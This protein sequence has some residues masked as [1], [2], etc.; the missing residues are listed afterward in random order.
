M[1]EIILSIGMIVKNEIR[2]L[3]KCL[4]ALEPLRKAVSCELVIADTGSTD[5]TREIAARY[6][7][8]FFDQ[9]WENDFSAARNAVL[10]RCTGQWFFM[11]DAD[12]YLDENIDELVAFLRN[13]ANKKFDFCL[14][15]NSSF[16]DRTLDKSTV[17]SFLA[18]RLARRRPGLR[19]VGKIHER[20]NFIDGD[21]D[22]FYSLSSVVLWHDGYAYETQEQVRRKMQRNMELLEE[23]LRLKPKEPLRIVQCIEASRDAEERMRYIQ[24]G[25]TEILADAPGWNQQGAV[26]LSYAVQLAIM[27]GSEKLR[28]WAELAYTRYPDSPMTQIDLNAAMAVHYS[29]CYQ[30]QEALKAA[31][32][33]WEGVQKLERNE[34]PLGVFATIS[35]HFNSQASREDMA[36]LQAEACH[37]LNRPG[38]AVRV[39]QTV[40]LRTISLP[41]IKR[42]VN[43]LA[44]LS[45]KTN[46]AKLFSGDAK[47]ILKEEPASREDWGRR[48]ALRKALNNMFEQPKEKRL[49]AS[50]L[51]EL[52][53]GVYA[54]AA[55][56]METENVETMQEIAQSIADWKQIPAAVVQKLV[57]TRVAMPELFFQT[58]EYDHICGLAR[59]L[60][61]H[62][63]NEAERILQIVEELDT[64]DVVMTVWRFKLLSELCVW[65]K[66]KNMKQAEELFQ[67]Y[68]KATDSYLKTVYPTELLQ[69]NYM[70]AVLPQDCRF[71]YGCLQAEKQLQANDEANC[72]HT[73]KDLLKMAPSMREMV[74][75]LTERVAHITQERRMRMAV[76]PQL[77]A[78]AKQVRAI[79]MQYPENSPT[80]FMLKSSE[81]YQ[82]MKFLI[83]D[84]NLDD[85]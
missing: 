70:Y 66:W 33:Y 5:G 80:A 57:E 54:P 2:C 85:M 45:D 12:E 68:C 78:M 71:A 38:L 62:L 63:D 67:A 7:D 84:P 74:R 83:E 18:V 42:L 30:W 73:L 3:E 58:M 46:V 10:D 40:P 17:T 15:V 60:V 4:K 53:D 16:T 64:S 41:N 19:F 29:K 1:S 76:T 75:F 20:F 50:V 48:D 72:I 55:A 37:H 26:L 21:G 39:L 36:L 81:Q 79:L 9:P 8:I 34:F 22:R 6:A 49:P 65:F 28:E 82:K 59:Y 24:M 27:T 23:E 31:D 77:I 47:K 61:R 32:A 35:L 69:P 11:V 13:S 14:V 51:E 56:I 52:Q 43:I 25:L 44:L